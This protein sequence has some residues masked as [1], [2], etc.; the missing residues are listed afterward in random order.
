MAKIPVAVQIYSVRELY[1]SDLHATLREV[2]G[3]G[4]EGVDFY[5]DV[6]LPA[7]ELRAVLDDLG[8]KCAGWHV[9]YLK[10]DQSFR[11]LLIITPS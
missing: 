5:G 1:K 4:Y 2:A 11:R 6:P 10:F 8:L 9:N 3:M 7:R